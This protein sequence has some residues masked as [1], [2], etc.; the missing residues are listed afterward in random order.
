MQLLTYF[1]PA[2]GPPHI[3][4][5]AAGQ[6]NAADD[7]AVVAVQ[8]G[9]GGP[10]EAHPAVPHVLLQVHPCLPP[11]LWPPVSCCRLWLHQTDGVV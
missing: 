7:S 6:C 5:A 4:P 1:S 8:P 2:R 11:P 3:D 10:A 9:G